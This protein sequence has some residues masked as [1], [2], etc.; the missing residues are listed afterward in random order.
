MEKRLSRFQEG[1]LIL[2]K[3]KKKGFM[4]MSFSW[5]FA[6]IVGAVV[7]FLA[8]YMATQLIKTQGTKQGAEISKDIGIVFDPLETGFEDSK[9][10]IL[11]IGI[12][13]KITNI[14]ENYGNFGSQGIRTSQKIFGKEQGGDITITFEN[15][16]IFSQ[17]I[18]EDSR[19]Y[20]FSRK[21]DFPFKVADLIFMIPESHTYC[22]ISPPQEIKNITYALNLSNIYNVTNAN[23]C[24]DFVI[25]RVCFGSGGN[26]TIRVNTGAK[27]VSKG[28]ELMK[29]GD[30]STMLAA[31]FSDKDIYECEMKRV[32][33]RVES[34]AYIYNQK[35]SFVS[36]KNCNSRANLDSLV[37]G[38][39]SYESSD[40]LAGL[41]G[42][43]NEIA[44]STNFAECQLW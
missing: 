21:F 2:G 44:R 34:L 10:T 39:S 7:L 3:M 24:P 12:R 31:I 1:S 18:I 30:E 19:F 27:T 36:S 17:K 16:Y 25:E 13:S 33:K 29:Y 15:K 38:A 9:T 5:L 6:L 14:C 20:I 8:I 26:C 43:K 11:D 23:S 37:F 22:L 42:A 40:D 28:A 32:I 41:Y 4:E 35:K